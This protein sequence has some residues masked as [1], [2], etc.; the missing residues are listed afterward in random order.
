MKIFCTDSGGVDD[1]E[2][3]I[4]ANEDAGELIMVPR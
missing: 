3:F 4:L 2:E 1:L